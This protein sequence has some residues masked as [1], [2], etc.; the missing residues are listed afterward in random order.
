MLYTGDDPDLKTIMRALD[1]TVSAITQTLCVWSAEE[2]ALTDKT[3]QHLYIRNGKTFHGQK[4]QDCFPLRMKNG[5]GRPFDL[6]EGPESL[7]TGMIC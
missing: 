1:M 4:P 5:D 6:Q 7:K 2:P 3:S